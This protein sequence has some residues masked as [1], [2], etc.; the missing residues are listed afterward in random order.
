MRFP[1]LAL[2]LVAWPLLLVRAKLLSSQDFDPSCGTKAS[3]TSLTTLTLLVAIEVE[4]MMTLG[5]ETLQKSFGSLSTDQQIFQQLL[6]GT[7]SDLATNRQAAAS[8]HPNA[9]RRSLT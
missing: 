8:K 6:M 7:G 2:P 4:E 1:Y 5:I 9:K 3:S